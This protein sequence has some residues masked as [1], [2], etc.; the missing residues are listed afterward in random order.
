VMTLTLIM[1]AVAESLCAMQD[2]TGV[3]L[4]I[5]ILRWRARC[6]SSR[7]CHSIVCFTVVTLLLHCCYTVVVIQTHI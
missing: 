6:T 7:C 5:H 2:S 3:H 1:M 4:A